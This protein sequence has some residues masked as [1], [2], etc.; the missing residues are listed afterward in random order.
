MGNRLPS[1]LVATAAED[2]LNISPINRGEMGF[3]SLS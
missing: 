3:G 1:R 2:R